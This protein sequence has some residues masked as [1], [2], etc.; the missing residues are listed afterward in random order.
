MVD[1]FEKL[2]ELKSTATNANKKA[3]SAAAVQ[4]PGPGAGYDA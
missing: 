1:N 3:P 4:E 2:T